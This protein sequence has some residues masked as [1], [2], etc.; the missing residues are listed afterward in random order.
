METHIMFIRT[1]ILCVRKNT[2]EALGQASQ[3]EIEVSQYAIDY[4]PLGLE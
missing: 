1:N 4:H 3:E 2:E